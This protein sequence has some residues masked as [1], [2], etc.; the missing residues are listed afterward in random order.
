[1]EASHI[2]AETLLLANTRFL[3]CFSNMKQFTRRAFAFGAVSMAMAGIVL[4]RFV[5][6]NQ[7]VVVR[8]G[9]FLKRS[10]LEL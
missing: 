9:W 10:D 1:M 7:G 6:P 2:A 3:W 5:R 8:N 4:S